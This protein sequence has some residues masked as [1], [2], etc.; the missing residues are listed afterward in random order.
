MWVFVTQAKRIMWSRPGSGFRR[1][2][3]LQKKTHLPSRNSTLARFLCII[4]TAVFV[5]PLLPK[6]SPQ[7]TPPRLRGRPLM[8]PLAYHRPVWGQRWQP[9]NKP[10]EWGGVTTSTSK[11][12]TTDRRKPY[13]HHVD[14]TFCCG[15]MQVFTQHSSDPTPNLKY[16]IVVSALS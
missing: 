12:S 11:Q 4:C 3:R 1:L 9:N 2:F 10:I 13:T 14:R 8:V 6:S 7:V 5:Y 16:T 15:A